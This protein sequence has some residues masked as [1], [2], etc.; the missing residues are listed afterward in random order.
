LTGAALL[1]RNPKAPAAIRKGLDYANAARMQA[2]LSGFAP[3]KSI[4]GNVGAAVAASGERK[5]LAPLRELLSMQTLRDVGS[6]YKAG[7]NIAPATAGVTLP[8]I[9][10][11]PGRIMGAADEATRNALV[12]AGLTAKEAETAVLQAPLDPRLSSALESPL[13]RYAIPFRRTP[14]NQFTEGLEVSKGKHP[15]VLGAYLGAGAAHGAATADER[16]PVTLPF[17]VAASAKYGLP[18]GVAAAAGRAFAGGKNVD[19]GAALSSVLPVSE[20][21][22]AQSIEDPLAPLKEPAAL[23]ALKTLQGRR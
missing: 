3:I 17:G 19:A 13:G 18:Y 12:R 22:I 1:A 7:R 21:G 8:G 2:M 6:A 9:L 4:L 16:F 11:A 10:G 5:S 14:F 20:F 15:V 23:R